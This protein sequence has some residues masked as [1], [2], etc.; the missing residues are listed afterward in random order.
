ML[1]FRVWTLDRG[2]ILRPFSA[3]GTWEPGVNTAACHSEPNPRHIPP[4]A[5]CSCG[6]Y[7]LHDD[8]DRRFT[9]WFNDSGHALGAIAAWGEMEV[10]WP[11][12]RAQHACVVALVLPQR[13]TATHERKLREAADRYRVDLVS[14]DQLRRAGRRHADWLPGLAPRRL[15]KAAER[16]AET[17]G[18]NSP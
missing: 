8:R 12:F 13:A 7:A 10:H 17:V 3:D 4:V 11:G 6:F 9:S 14:R 1:G 15:E 2:G 18:A 5:D 16:D